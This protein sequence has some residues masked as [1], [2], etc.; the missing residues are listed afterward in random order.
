M[1]VKKEGENRFFREAKM[2]FNLNNIHIAGGSYVDPLLQDNPKLRDLRVDIYYT[3]LVLF[4][5]SYYV[6]MR[7]VE[8][9]CEII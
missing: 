3:L 5:I 7:L 8:V 2:M 4:G 1:I 9:I 6:D